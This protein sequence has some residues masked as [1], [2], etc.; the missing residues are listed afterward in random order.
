[1]NSPCQSLSENIFVAVSS[2]KI[3]EHTNRHSSI[4]Y[5]DNFLWIKSVNLTLNLFYSFSNESAVIK[6]FKLF[7]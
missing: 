1:M 4:Y 7:S 2:S 3:E 6:F 5:D